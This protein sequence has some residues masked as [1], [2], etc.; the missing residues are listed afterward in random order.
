[1]PDSP[2]MLPAPP[3]APP[4]VRVGGLTMR[5]PNGVTALAGL[6][7]AVPKGSVGLVG[8]NGAGK[9]TMFRLLL[10]LVAPTAGWVEVAGRSVADDPVGVRSRVGYMPEHDCL[11]LDQSAADLVATFGEIAGLPARAA[12]QRA[13]DMLD[14]VGLDEA[15]FRPVGGFST[16]MRQRTKLATALVADPELV[17]L[18]EPT[19]GLDPV[20]REEM[21]GL[22]GRLSGFGISVL[23]AT[24]LLDD[25]QRV[26]E[27]VVMIDRGHL[28]LAGPIDQLTQRTGVMRVEVGGG[29]ADGDGRDGAAR[30]LGAA[31]GQRGVNAALVDEQTLDIDT[32]RRDDTFD[33][34]RDTVAELGLRLYSLSTRHRSLDDL[35]VHRGPQ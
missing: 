24:H 31:I 8:A 23:M 25:V 30:A 28:V 17:L 11:P 29:P 21:L 13:S 15:R 22:V 14:L 32:S 1:M 10:G 4:V 9:T 7:V 16:G 5:Y 19:A 20:G 3:V 34:V 2:Q 18:D 26:C 12:R 27:H 33:L 6:D 35:F